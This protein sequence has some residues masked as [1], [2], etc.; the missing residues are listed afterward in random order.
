MDRFTRMLAA[1]AV[2]IL[3]G[4][5]EAADLYVA[6]GGNDANPGTKEQPFASL[7]RA[8]DAAREAKA[9]GAVTVHVR[10]G[11]YELARPLEFTAADSGTQEQPVTWRASDDEQP[12]VSGGTV[13]AGWRR[14]DDT[15]WAA[16]VPW[17]RERGRP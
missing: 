9:A 16:D 8:R 3:L 1:A 7:E 14:H 17:V 2:V 11:R 10:G 15:L 6:P 12:V 4:S 13:V 5:A